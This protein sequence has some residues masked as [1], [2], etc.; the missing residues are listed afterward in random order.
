MAL[1]RGWLGF[2]AAVGL[3]FL[4]LLRPCEILSLTLGNILTPI[5]LCGPADR[6]FLRLG[7]TKTSHRGGALHQHVR[8]DDAVFVPFVESIRKLPGAHEGQRLVLG[9]A[10]FRKKWN[11]IMME[12]GIVPTR[13]HGLT[14]AGLRAGGATHLFTATQDI[15]LV[16]WRG[17]WQADRTLEH[18]LQELG[19]CSMLAAVPFNIRSKILALAEQTGVLLE[20]IIVQLA[21]LPDRLLLALEND[22]NRKHSEASPRCLRRRRSA[23][24]IW[25]GREA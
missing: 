24:G 11:A 23:S 12:L 8:I 2:A 6:L 3:G 18:Y 25:G 16:K 4:V 15:A 1:L 10:E 7:Q 9:A 20:H 21:P 22:A 17:R 14:P 13:D 5:A 19:S